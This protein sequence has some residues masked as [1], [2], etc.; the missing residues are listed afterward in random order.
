MPKKRNIS[1]LNSLKSNQSTETTASRIS[2]Y[3]RRLNSFYKEL[4]FL[5]FMSDKHEIARQDV[6][7]T[8]DGPVELYRRDM[9]GKERFVSKDRLPK[10]KD[11]NSRSFIEK[12]SIN[13]DDYSRHSSI[14]IYDQSIYDSLEAS[15]SSAIFRNPSNN[16]YGLAFDWY[17]PTGRLSQVLHEDVEVLPSRR[18]HKDKYRLSH[19]PQSSRALS[20]YSENF[21]DD[22]S[23]LAEEE[24]IFKKNNYDIYEY[25]EYEVDKENG[26]PS[27]YS[28]RR[29]R[30][31]RSLTPVPSI[32][33]S[34]NSRKPRKIVS[35]I[36]YDTH[37]NP[38]LQK[39]VFRHK[40]NKNKDRASPSKL[41][42]EERPQSIGSSPKGKELW[43]KVDVYSQSERLNN[44]PARV[45]ENKN[46][47]ENFILKE[48]N[49]SKI[50]THQQDFR[51]EG[52]RDSQPLSNFWGNITLPPIHQEDE[53][54]QK[55]ESHLNKQNQKNQQQLQQQSR[56][57]NNEPAD[58]LITNK[59]SKSDDQKNDSIVNF[60]HNFKKRPPIKSVMKIA[61]EMADHNNGKNEKNSSSKFDDIPGNNA[62]R[63]TLIFNLLSNINPS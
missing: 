53:E 22:Y 41:Q 39:V 50:E 60:R 40:K 18:K 37:D 3:K 43:K 56:Y 35:Y 59:P 24:K 32:P 46:Y 36:D 5:T 8:P 45:L 29:R 55:E 47:D 2:D 49:N 23:D 27:F 19:S 30:S 63:F 52:H 54:K 26:K 17:N 51:R 11:R 9:N 48:N 4:K 13:Q 14:P 10:I 28:S 7:I 61:S 62:L 25:Y 6:L 15:R 58:S 57:Q 16:R 21:Y 44:E 33:L 1:F 20:Y 31:N 42:I 34:R 38:S 12:I